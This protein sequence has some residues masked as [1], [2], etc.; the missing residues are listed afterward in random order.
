MKIVEEYLKLDADYK[1]KYGAKTFLLYQVGSFF[2]VYGLENT[3]SYNEK[4]T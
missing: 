3:R 2:E 1:N 4:Y